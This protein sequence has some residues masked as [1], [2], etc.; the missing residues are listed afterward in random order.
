MR[1]LTIVAIL[2]LTSCRTVSAPDGLPCSSA[3]FRSNPFLKRL[4]R[5]ET[6]AE[7]E[8]RNQVN[9]VAFGYLAAQWTSFKSTLLPGDQLWW[10]EREPNR[11]MQGAL[12]GYVV[13]RGCR[14]VDRFVV[15]TD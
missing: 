1:W 7:A 10:F 9:G 5:R 4:V 13:L 15:A 6:I 3:E 11:A 8:L 2:L 12:A 14:I